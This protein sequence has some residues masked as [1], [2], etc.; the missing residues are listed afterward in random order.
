MKKSVIVQASSRS[1][2]DT[3]KIVN[4]IAT[5][6]GMDVIDLRT[7]NIGHYDY[8]YKN[9]GDDFLSL[10]THII[11]TYDIIIFATPVYWYSMSGILKVFFDRIS[12]LLRVHKDTGRKLRGKN[13][14]MISSS[15]SD[16]LKEGFSMPF[17]ES[18]NY[19]GMNY[20][21]DIHVYIENDSINNEVKLR[22]DA[23][24][25]TINNTI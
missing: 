25:E 4:Y 14:A 5:N 2:G 6:N 10:I 17:V 9:E 22:I 8:E 1:H 12:D 20:L 3:N 11:E 16:D 13:M 21:G 18:A 24:V 7:K 23:F 15:N 19:L